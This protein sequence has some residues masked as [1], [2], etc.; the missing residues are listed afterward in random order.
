MRLGIA[1]IL[2][3]SKSS[4]LDS[5]LVQDRVYY[6]AQGMDVPAGTQLG[7]IYVQHSP[8]RAHRTQMSNFYP[9][10]EAKRIEVQRDQ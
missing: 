3:G 8:S 6:D 2:H 10:A 4:T 9:L 1:Q 5:R 7:V